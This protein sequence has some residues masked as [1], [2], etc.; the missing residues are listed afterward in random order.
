MNQWNTGFKADVA[1]TNTSGEDIG[2][3]TLTWTFADGQQ[4]TGA[5]NAEVVQ[6]GA[7]VSAGNPER[8][9]NGTIPANGG[10][11]HFGFQGSHSG[12]NSVP[13][14]FELNGVACNDE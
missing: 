14:D 13:V 1:V 3:W 8:H 2:G 4:V 5:W 10:R 7:D 6:S 12:V 11:V 9:W